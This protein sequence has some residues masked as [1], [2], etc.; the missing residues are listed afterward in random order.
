MTIRESVCSVL[1]RSGRPSWLGR[2]ENQTL[3]ES[4]IIVFL[5]GSDI[6]QAGDRESRR[7]NGTLVFTG[8]DPDVR[9]GSWVF[10]A[11]PAFPEMSSTE[12]HTKFV[13]LG[14]DF[15]VVNVG[16]R[17]SNRPGKF[18]TDITLFA[19]QKSVLLDLHIKSEF[20]SFVK[21]KLQCTLRHMINLL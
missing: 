11:V 17:I 19:G 21:S 6:R 2:P 15:R 16:D 14:G 9:L 5:G 8:G 4:R 7:E 18:G 1:V 3:P 20:D 13:C 12:V 10:N